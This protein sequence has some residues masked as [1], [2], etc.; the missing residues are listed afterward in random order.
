MTST[1]QA[2]SIPPGE[3][4]NPHSQFC[5]AFIPNWLLRR[6]ELCHGAKLVYGRLCQYAGK[7]GECYPKLKTLAD[8][9]SMGLSTVHKYIGHLE[10]WGLIKSIRR[11]LGRPNKYLFL[12][13]I[14]MSGAFKSGKIVA[15]NDPVETDHADAKGVGQTDTLDVEIGGASVSPAAK[16]VS[17]EVESLISTRVESAPLKEETQKKNHNNTDPKPNSPT[18]KERLLSFFP[19]KIKKKGLPDLMATIPEAEQK[20]CKP[21]IVKALKSQSFNYVQRAIDYVNFRNPDSYGAYLR[22]T[23]RDGYGEQWHR[24]QAEKARIETERHHQAQRRVAE[25]EADKARIDAE[26]REYE[27]RRQR[28]FSMPAGEL[29]E[30]EKEFAKTLMGLRS[31]RYLK[32]GLSAVESEFVSYVEKVLTQSKD[33]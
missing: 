9:L 23:L 27:K 20:G 5:G 24:Q 14:W 10:Q 30:L 21:I 3:I 12:T 29:A 2:A 13:H 19:K 17:T 7:N 6:P 26:N 25:M 28:V 1:A 8:E 33:E 16:P 4:F 15:E 22:I 31:K 11:G 32:K 18:I